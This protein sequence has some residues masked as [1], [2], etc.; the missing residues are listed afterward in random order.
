MRSSMRWSSG[1]S[2]FRGRED[3]VGVGR[4]CGRLVELRE[5]ERRQEFVA[6]RALRLPYSNGGPEGFFGRRRVRV[7][8]LEQK[9]TAEAMKIRVLKMVARLVRNRQSLVD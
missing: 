8:A 1:R 4:T 2:A 7:V 6:P 9:I 3:R 5:R